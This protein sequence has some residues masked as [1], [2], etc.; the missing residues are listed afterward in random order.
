MLTMAKRP[1][2][3]QMQ[4]LFNQIETVEG[5]YAEAMDKAKEEVEALKE[6]IVAINAEAKEYYKMYVL[7][8]ITLESYE[9][10]KQKSESKNK[11]LHVAEGKVNSIDELKHEELV[12]IHK[13]IEAIESEYRVENNTNISKQ[14]QQM[15]KAKIDYLKALHQARNEVDKTDKYDFKI[16]NLNVDLGFKRDYGFDFD[17]RHVSNLLSNPFNNRAGIDVNQEEI[18]SAYHNGQIKETVIKEAGSK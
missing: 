2:T 12:N 15:F 3:E 18:A 16:Y 17:D 4:Q 5:K 8:E 1:Y 6:E 10:L 9:E 13:Q 14:R 7:D 11:M